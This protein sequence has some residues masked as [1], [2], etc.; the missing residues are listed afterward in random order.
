MWNGLMV[1]KDYWEPRNPQDF[2]YAIRDQVA[3]AVVRPDTDGTVWLPTNTPTVVPT[4]KLDDDGTNA[5]LFSVV[6]LPA[7]APAYMRVAYELT[8]TSQTLIAFPASV[9][10]APGLVTLVADVPLVCGFLINSIPTAGDIDAFYFQLYNYLG[11]GSVLINAAVQKD[12]G[13]TTGTITAQSGTFPPSVSGFGTPYS[14]ELVGTKVAVEMI[15]TAGVLTATMFVNGS[16]IGT[17]V[18][19]AT[20]GGVFADLQIADGTGAGGV[21]DISIVPTV[22][23]GLDATYGTFTAG[24]VDMVGASL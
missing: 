4:Y 24:A 16:A 23:S 15:L 1:H 3:P 13:A 18:G 22:A 12:T 7:I 21:M 11:A 2:I 8:A 19:I 10:A 5:A 14:G 20:D 9:T 17:S 6:H